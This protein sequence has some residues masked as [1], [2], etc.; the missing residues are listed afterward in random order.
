MKTDTKAP[1]ASQEEP[2]SVEVKVTKVRLTFQRN[3][4]F[5]LPIGGRIAEVFMPGET[6][7]VD[8]HL[9]AHP[10]FQVYRDQFAV[11]EVE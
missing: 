4:R 1:E 10:D 6:K 5:E 2:V 7:D 9:V 8:A 3:W 11:Q